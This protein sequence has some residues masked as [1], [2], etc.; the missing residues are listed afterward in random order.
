M[1]QSYTKLDRGPVYGSRSSGGVFGP[2]VQLAVILR[3]LDGAS[4][5]DLMMLF[6]LDGL[7]FT[8]L[9]ICNVLVMAGALASEEIEVK[10]LDDGFAQSRTD[11]NQ[12]YG[13]AGAFHGKEIE[14]HEPDD[15]N[16]PW[17][18]YCRRWMYEISL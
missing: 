17:N 14:M 9:F 3:C 13:C 16:V 7:K 4:Y 10:A 2:A 15:I 18:V 1:Q 5:L 12:L 8:T 6:N 11:E